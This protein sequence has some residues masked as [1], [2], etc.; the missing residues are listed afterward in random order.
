MRI[1]KIEGERFWDVEQACWIDEETAKAKENRG[2]EVMA[3]IASEGVSDEKYLIRTLEFSHYP[4]GELALLSAQGIKDEFLKLDA[5]YLTP[6]T[7]A[8]LSAGDTEAG[9]RWLEHERLARP[10]RERLRELEE[11]EAAS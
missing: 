10:L 5:E 7:L 9:D 4:L 3:L 8:G 2:Y 11:N 6:R 1:F